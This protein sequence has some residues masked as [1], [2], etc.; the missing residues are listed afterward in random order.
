VFAEHF[1]YLDSMRGTGRV[2]IAPQISSK[3]AKYKAKT[4]EEFTQDMMATTKE[5]DAR[6]E[7]YKKV[8]EDKAETI[9]P[10]LLVTLSSDLLPVI[11]KLLESRLSE[12]DRKDLS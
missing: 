5:G 3:E 7:M 1:A 2:A 9:G 11:I 12:K 6:Y 8:L 10:G 4:K